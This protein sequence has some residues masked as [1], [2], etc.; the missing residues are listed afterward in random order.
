MTR[1]GRH[2]YVEWQGQQRPRVEV[3]REL[4]TAGVPVASIARQLGVR[5]Q[6]VYM[7]VRGMEKPSAAAPGRR[8]LAAPTDADAIL[9]GCVSQKNE[10]PMPAKDLYRSE[11]FR[12][13]RLWAEAS[14]KPWWIVSAEYGLVGPDEEIRPY[15]TRI[16]QLPLEARHT[17]ASQVATD[18]EAR[19]GPLNGRTLELHA[20]DD[21]YL[22][23]APMLE[24]Q[25]A[26]VVRPLEGLRIGEQLGW[27]GDHLGLAGPSAPLKVQQP[28]VKVSGLI[29]DGRGLSPAITQRF[30]D[31]HLDLSSR[32]KQP[33][34]GWAG[35]PEVRA[36][37]A[38]RAN[39]ASAIQI[40]LFLTFNAAM[41]RARDA[42]QLADAAVQMWRKAAWPFAPEAIVNRS[43]GE[44]G[45]T[46]RT[47][48]VSQRHG[49][50][51]FA[52]RIIAESLL[53]PSV[54]PA[55]RSA[56]YDGH[57]DAQQLLDEVMSTAAAGTPR[58]P[59][60]GGP[61]ISA[62]WVRLLAHPGRA[63]IS[64]LEVVPVAV[65]VQVRKL[66]EYLAVTDTGGL[67]LQDVRAAIQE[68]WRRDVATNGA[69]GPAGLENTP[70]ALDPA[71]WFYAKW[72]CT[73]CELKKTKS[74]ISPLCEQ[75]RYPD[76]GEPLSGGTLA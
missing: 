64:S 53:D 3:I 4:F 2:I 56:I 45:E 71:L 39:G 65:D 54:S 29:G 34:I 69:S 51:A 15:D 43:L 72:G 6:I 73:Y 50:D 1:D 7:A 12:R 27:Y 24:K 9:I 37:E 40:R 44:L 70:G 67:P 32:P 28:H 25:G 60:L 76:A 31:G 61:K 58:F 36:A 16:G 14:G 8:Q 47:F 66:T 23:I 5:Y 75:C 26:R 30:M 48:G 10:V 63:R 74:P 20:G 68:T 41:D 11:L 55:A 33:Q 13:R 38:L 57:A 35:M 49:Q 46:L 42:D 18:L 62:L 22:A 21:Y 52:W 17:L 19:L 59:L